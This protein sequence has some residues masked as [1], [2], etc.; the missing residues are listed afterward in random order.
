MPIYIATLYVRDPSGTYLPPH[1]H[2]DEAE[3]P[4]AFMIKIREWWITRYGR[5]SDPEFGPIGLAKDQP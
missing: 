4:E 3:S 2:R 5:E 1:V